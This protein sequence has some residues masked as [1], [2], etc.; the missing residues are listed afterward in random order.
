MLGLGWWLHFMILEVFSNLNDSRVAVEWFIQRLDKD[1]RGGGHP[2]IG[3][4]GLEWAPFLSKL[5][6]REEPR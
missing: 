5:L 6:L 3:L 2:P 4:Q 1:V